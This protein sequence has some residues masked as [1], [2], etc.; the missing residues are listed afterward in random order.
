[1]RLEHYQFDGRTNVVALAP[2]CLFDNEARIA[3]STGRL[4]V[5]GMNGVLRIVGNEGFL[6]NMTNSALVVSNRV[7]T[8]LRQ[9]PNNRINQ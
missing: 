1:M 8:V 7:R 5:V 9:E 2:E 6:V 4:E 3:W